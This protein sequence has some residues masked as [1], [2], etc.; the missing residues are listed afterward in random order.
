MI[1]PLAQRI[2]D[3]LHIIESEYNPFMEEI[4]VSMANDL[5]DRVKE[6]Y[7][8]NPL[9][10][11]ATYMDPRFRPLSFLHDHDQISID[12]STSAAQS[13]IKTLHEK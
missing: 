9:I 13:Y 12:R 10:L 1:L 8:N 5:S 2:V 3:N 6:A 4:A 7:L 11:A